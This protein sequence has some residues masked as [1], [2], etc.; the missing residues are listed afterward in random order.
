MGQ[1][2]KHKPGDIARLSRITEAAFM[3]AQA[4]LRK[5]AA[6][7]AR[8]QAEIDQLRQGRHTVLASLLVTEER[9]AAQVTCH[10]TWLTW[11][12]Q[13]RAR[14]NMSLARARAAALQEREHARKA[15]G[16][17]QVA[18]ALLRRLQTH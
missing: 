12:D 17:D 2:V 16:R 13:R 3:V 4:E 14:L 8:I 5:K 7:E 15:F 9:S 18:Q 10:G 6:V 11:A 1:D